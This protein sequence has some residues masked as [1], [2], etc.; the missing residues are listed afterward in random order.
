MTES[1]PSGLQGEGA[2]DV[3]SERWSRRPRR[4][5]VCVDPSHARRHWRQR[6]TSVAAGVS[7][8][9]ACPRSSRGEGVPEFLP[10]AVPDGYAL[11]PHWPGRRQ[12]RLRLGVSVVV[13]RGPTAMGRQ[14]WSPTHRAPVRRR[15]ESSNPWRQAGVDHRHTRRPFHRLV[16]RP[17]QSGRCLRKPHNSRR[18]RRGVRSSTRPI[19]RPKQPAE[20]SSAVSL[21]WRLGR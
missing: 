8:V 11:S 12:C 20:A 7:R 17:R 4:F 21:S 14:S 3:C 2:E 13:E 18:G 9:H 19:L 16:V 10:T 6:S 15:D 1:P 5:R